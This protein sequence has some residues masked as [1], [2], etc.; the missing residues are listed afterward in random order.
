MD[1]EKHKVEAHTVA[2]LLKQFFKELPEP[3]F[4]FSVSDTILTEVGAWKES[5]ICCPFLFIY[6]FL[7]IAE[8][9]PEQKIDA[10]ITAR[11]LKLVPPTHRTTIDHLFL[12]LHRVTDHSEKN[13][14]NSMNLALGLH[15]LIVYL[16][17][18][19]L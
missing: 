8:K 19:C 5:V 2:G 1:F 6:L 7:F 17:F 4:T 10:T 16:I 12:F 15:H 9:V 11:L 3:L 18:H 13:M 14:M